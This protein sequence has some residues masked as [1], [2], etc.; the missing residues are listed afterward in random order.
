MTRYREYQA[1]LADQLVGDTF[2]LAAAFL[3]RASETCLAPS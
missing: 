1:W 3:R 2:R